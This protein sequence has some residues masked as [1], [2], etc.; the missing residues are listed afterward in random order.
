MHFFTLQDNMPLTVAKMVVE[1]L[2]I[3]RTRKKHIKIL[4]QNG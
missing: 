2:L 4:Y 3:K 1:S